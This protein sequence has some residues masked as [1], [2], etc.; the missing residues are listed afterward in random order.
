M[1]LSYI[2]YTAYSHPVSPTFLFPALSVVPCV[3]CGRKALE[4]APCFVF[5]TSFLAS[6]SFFDF[7]SDFSAAT[8][9]TTTSKY[10]VKKNA[11]IVICYTKYN[12]DE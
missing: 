3:S 5:F 10:I 2:L 7:H 1:L 4:L 6:L 12:S 9:H 8:P 11:I